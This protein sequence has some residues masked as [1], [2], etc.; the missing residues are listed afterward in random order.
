MKSA[1]VVLST[2]LALAL[3]AQTAPAAT[4]LPKESEAKK[5]TAPVAKAAAAKQKISAAAAQSTAAAR[6][7]Q[8]LEDA[9]KRREAAEARRDAA[10]VGM[11]IPTATANGTGATTGAKGAPDPMALRAQHADRF[12]ISPAASKPS[13]FDRADPA[14]ARAEAQRKIFERTTA[15]LAPETA[16]V[17]DPTDP[18]L[19]ARGGLPLGG[20]G[21]E[22]LKSIVR[23]APGDGAGPAPYDSASVA[24]GKRPFFRLQHSAGGDGMWRC[25]KNCA[26]NGFV[27]DELTDTAGLPSNA[28]RDDVNDM[29]TTEK[30]CRENP[31]L[32][33]EA[34]RSDRRPGENDEEYWDRKA[35]EAHAAHQKREDDKLKKKASKD[36]SKE[37]TRTAREDCQFE[38]DLA[39]AELERRRKEEEEKRKKEEA[40]KKEDKKDAKD[41]ALTSGEDCDGLPDDA[42]V[43]WHRATQ[44]QLLAATGAGRE[45]GPGNIDPERGPAWHEGLEAKAVEILG[46]GDPPEDEGTPAGDAPDGDCTTAPGTGAIDYGP[47]RADGGTPGCETDTPTFDAG[48]VLDLADSQ[49]DDGE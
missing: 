30:L 7:K 16:K 42:L 28:V 25:V 17:P 31:K 41:C 19:P 24:K 39:Q 43:D 2:A 48:A 23:G 12:P 3:A 27:E 35:R 11:R 34:G 10:A 32:C 9:R 13:P 4:R 15:G 37:S 40:K 36:C 29:T 44:Q 47:D 46:V 22:A 14:A 21:T 20:A 8:A 5:S 33:E 6:A 18:T 49:D 26:Q 38:K 1:T 45:A